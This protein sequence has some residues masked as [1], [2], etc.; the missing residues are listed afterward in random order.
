MKFLFWIVAI[1]LLFIAGFF[2]VAN[3]EIDK[4]LGE[5]YQGLPTYSMGRFG[6]TTSRTDEVV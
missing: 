2:A 3:R 6:E 5:D 4:R 1:A